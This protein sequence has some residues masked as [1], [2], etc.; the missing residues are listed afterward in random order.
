MKLNVK[1]HVYLQTIFRMLRHMHKSQ[2]SSV[3][4]ATGC[5]LDNWGLIAG[6]DWEFFS[7]TLCLDWFWGPPSLLSNGYQ[8]LF[9]WG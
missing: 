8:G 4:I 7:L 6:G 1:A 5:G 2:N 3:S 9:P